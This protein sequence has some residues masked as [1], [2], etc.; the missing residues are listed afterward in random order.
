LF[1]ELTA[2]LAAGV[3]E[4]EMAVRVETNAFWA[5]DLD[6]A[7][8]YLEPLFRAGSSV[9][10]S[11]DAFHEPYISLDCIERAVRV[12][13]ELGMEHNL[14]LPYLDVQARTH[15]LD[16]RTDALLRELERRLD[17][18]PCCRTYQGNVLYNGRAADRLASI[19]APGRGVPDVICDRV[20]WWYDG[21]IETNDLLILDPEGYLSKGC[22]IS[23]GNVR[24]LPVDEVLAAFDAR[25]HPIFSTLL[26][27]GPL[28]L[29]KEATELGYTLK[30]D[31][32]DKC[33]LCQE[34]R[35]VLVS[36]YPNELVPRQHYL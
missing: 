36:K 24:E 10:F 12:A 13:D 4:M 22:G 34:A 31:Y 29:A 11:L 33:H 6:A 20:P 32:A 35:D 19:V 25:R 1:P 17:R 16:L 14:E 21:W 2:S 9:M 26:T 23:M 30:Q 8:S 15:A 27:S 3:H 7:L 28:G 5:T 18:S